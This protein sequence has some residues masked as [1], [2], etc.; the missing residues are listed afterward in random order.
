VN[1]D[2][3]YQSG[4]PDVYAAAVGNGATAKVHAAQVSPGVWEADAGQVGP[5]S[6]PATPGSVSIS[7]S[8]RCK[9]F[10]T[11]VNTPAG[12]FWEL[13]VTSQS[14]ITKAFR[15]PAGF[16]ARHG[17]VADKA[18][19]KSA[20]PLV[21]APGHSGRIMVTITPQ[22]VHGKVVRGNLY[23]DSVDSFLFGGNE[24]AAL[25]YTYTIK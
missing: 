21:L 3:F 11:T 6:G 4:E 2:F 20:V 24:L 8:A 25:P 22:G 18:S 14:A 15:L 16:P 9:L 5:F 23:V 19:S 10:D 7:A 17:L 13:G 12:D 1:L